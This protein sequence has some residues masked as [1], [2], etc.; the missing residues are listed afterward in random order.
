VGDYSTDS[1]L[2]DRHRERAQR[3]DQ[4]V[5]PLADSAY[6]LALTML[7]DANEAEDAVQ[8]AA[9][10]AWR[11][12]DRLRDREAARPWFLA[13]VANQCRT[14]RRGRWWSTAR[15]ADPIVWQDGVEQAA[16]AGMDLR[17][18]LDRLTVDERLAL[19]LYFVEDLPLEQAARILRLSISAARSRMYRALKR[20]RPGLE[21]REVAL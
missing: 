14:V 6:R 15:V 5:G 21:V 3:F 16:V 20:L 1:A 11:N 10:Q 19:H 18:A 2:D 13:I 12:L 4:L 17:R 8:E 9:L 7:R